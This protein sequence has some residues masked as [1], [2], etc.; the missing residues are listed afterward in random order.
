MIIRSRSE[1]AREFCAIDVAKISESRLSLKL[2]KSSSISSNGRPPKSDFSAFNMSIFAPKDVEAQKENSNPL[3][4]KASEGLKAMCAVLKSGEADGSGSVSEQEWSG[5]VT[6][7][8]FART[9][10]ETPPDTPTDTP[11]DTSPDNSPV[12]KSE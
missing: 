12:E 1:G 9:P 8:L 3:W 7:P 5:R 4:S 10:P 2:A 11:R 6:P